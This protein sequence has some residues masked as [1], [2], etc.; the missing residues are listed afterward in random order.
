MR[1]RATKYCRWEIM[2]IVWTVYVSLS[3][4]PP[5]PLIPMPFTS[6]GPQ[7]HR[8]APT[9][10]QALKIP[11]FSLDDVALNGESAKHALVF[12]YGT[13]ARKQTTS[14]FRLYETSHTGTARLS[15]VY[16][17]HTARYENI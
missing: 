17:L 15:A 5:T 10:V 2:F 9:T 11:S 16:R 7:T 14:I 8:F 13:Q 1:Q 4:A 6:N 12:L 3:A